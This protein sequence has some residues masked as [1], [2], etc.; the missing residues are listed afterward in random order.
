M[1]D[2][3]KY[4]IIELCTFEEVIEHMTDVVFDYGLSLIGDGEGRHIPAPVTVE[5]NAARK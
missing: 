3:A 2:P 1:H 4:Y 5:E